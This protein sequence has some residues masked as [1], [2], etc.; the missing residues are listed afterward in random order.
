MASV[1][2][3]MII[4][5]V[6][7]NTCSLW[8]TKCGQRGNC[9]NYDYDKLGWIIVSYAIPLKAFSLLFYFLS[10]YYCKELVDHV[11]DDKRDGVAH[12]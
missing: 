7:D 2:G 12:D 10:W 6:I 3:P 4:G 9:L 8:N 1:P 5:Y 11:T